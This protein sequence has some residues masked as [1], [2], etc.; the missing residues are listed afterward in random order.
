MTYRRRHRWLR[1][2]ALGLA[3][4]AFAAPAA[5][6]PDEGGSG[7]TLVTAGGWS[8]LVDKE[9]GIPLSAGIPRG[10]EPFLGDESLQVIPYLSHGILTEADQA[11]AAAE[12][13]HDPYLTDVFV[14]QGESQ[15]GPDG[16][17]IAIKN[18]LET[19]AVAKAEAIHDPYLTDVFVRQ[20]E[21][22]GGPD[23]EELA[24]AR[25]V[26][27]AADSLH[28]P[29]GGERANVSPS[30]RG[31]MVK[32]RQPKEQFVQGVTDFPKPTVVEEPLVI[33]Y[34]SHGMAVDGEVGARPDDK[35]DRFAHSDVASTSDVA[36]SRSV[37]WNDGASLA[38]GTV[39]LALA[40]GL[41]L[42]YLKRPRLAGL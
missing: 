11:A 33:S 41:G 37:E 19:Q 18:A 4:A 21:S 34:L 15:G 20:G 36:G 39:V 13:I 3:F 26:V 2:L 8:G 35:A 30:I 23:G 16:D 9:T 7:S 1:R 42:G 24:F 5:A 38:I 31:E 32:S 22:L 28:D 29:I 25:A 17:E 14:R 27:A 12:A 10:D 40:L 6:R